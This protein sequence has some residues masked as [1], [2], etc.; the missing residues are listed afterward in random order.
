MR[1]CR[2][3]KNG[4]TQISWLDVEA[5]DAGKYTSLKMND[6]T[7]DENWRIEAVYEFVTK[8]SALLEKEKARKNNWKS[9]KT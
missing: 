4:V 1:Q 9:I 3:Y 8:K 5:S 6:G 2:I 7:M